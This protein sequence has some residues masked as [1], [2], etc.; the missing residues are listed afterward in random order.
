MWQEMTDGGVDDPVSGKLLSGG[1]FP[2]SREKCR[3]NPIF[4]IAE[5]PG[6]PKGARRIDTFD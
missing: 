6:L 1:I 3:E 2:A 4:A 5:W